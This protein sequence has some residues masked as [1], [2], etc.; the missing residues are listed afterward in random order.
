MRSF[1]EDRL[2]RAK[3][4]F[5]YYNGNQFYMDLNGDGQKYRAYHISEETEEQ[6]RW[7]YLIGFFEEKRYGRDALGSYVRAVDFI[8]SDRSDRDRKEFLYYPL[9]ADWL[10]D[11]TVLFMLPTSFR[12][13]E[14]WAEKGKISRE[15][16]AEYVKA[17]D[18]Y[19]ERVIQRAGDGTLTRADDYTMHE[20]SDPDYDAGYLDDLRKKW[21]GLL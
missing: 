19:I 4:L 14:K 10:D 12:L 18:G 17:L 20:F 8:G 5:F 3:E 15:E 6:W 16:I 13:A 2:E 7:E 1:E 9:K 11:V 21:I